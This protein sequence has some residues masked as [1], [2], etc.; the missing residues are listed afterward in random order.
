MTT[1]ELIAVL[2]VIHVLAA[3]LMIWPFYALVA[4]NQRA[5]LGPPL[6]DR[7]D[8]YLEDIIKN[9]TIPCYVFQATALVSGLALVWLH[10]GGLGPLVSEPALGLKFL[11]LLALA[12]SLTYVYLGLQPRIDALFVQGAGQP[13]PTDLARAV[14]QLRLRRK[15]IASFCLFA[16]LAAAI[17]GVE[18]AHRFP[19]GLTIGL[20]VAAALFSWRSYRSVTPYGWV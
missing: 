4:V 15:R 13:L 18:A 20:V 9:R 3:V 2:R 1:G 7:V 17:L 11:L 19:L 5:R 6:G 12:G 8:T 14:S 10:D 16:V